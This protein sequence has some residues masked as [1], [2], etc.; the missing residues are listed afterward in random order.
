MRKNL[1]DRIHSQNNPIMQN[2]C[3]EFFSKHFEHQ[4]LEQ[5]IVI[6]IKTYLLM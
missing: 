2:S 1:M 3:L 4:F 6:E 5:N